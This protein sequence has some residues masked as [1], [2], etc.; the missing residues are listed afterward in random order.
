MNA[1]FKNPKMAL[2]YV[3]ITALGVAF[4][5]G[6]ED[7]PGTLHQ[8]V[9]TFEEADGA[10]SRTAGRG[11]PEI[12]RGTPPRRSQPPAQGQQPADSA[13]MEFAADDDLLDLAEGF[14]PTPLDS[15]EGFNP[16]P[17]QAKDGSWGDGQSGGWG[18]DTPEP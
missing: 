12:D 9:E 10:P 1:L 11:E 2:A 5:V 3:G 16:T 6:T 18:G 13:S 17:T 15:Y 7:S 4:F 14:N 8:T